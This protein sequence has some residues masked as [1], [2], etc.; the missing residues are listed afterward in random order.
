MD[1]RIANRMRTPDGTILHSRHRHDCVF[2][3]DTNGKTYMLD[4]GLGEYIRMSTNGDEVDVS[5]RLE[6][7]HDAVREIPIWGTRGKD[8]KQPIKFV[9]IKD[10]DTDHLQACLDTQDQMKQ[11]LRLAMEYEIKFRRS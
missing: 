10:M 5:V 7:G 1:T 8:G 11:S 9:A 3:T 4:G 6:D 2:H